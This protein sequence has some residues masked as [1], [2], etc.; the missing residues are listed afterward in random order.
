[1]VVADGCQTGSG[2]ELLTSR[3]L[4]GPLYWGKETPFLH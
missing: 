4:A 2:E 1:M 3:R